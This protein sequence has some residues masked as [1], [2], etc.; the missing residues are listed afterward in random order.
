MARGQTGD[1]ALQRPNAPAGADQPG[2]ATAI[3]W[4]QKLQHLLRALAFCLAIAAIQCAFMPAM[5]YRVAAGYSLAIGMPTWALI[6]LGRHLFPG[7][8]GRPWPAGIG[9]VLLPASAL[10]LSYLG[11]VQ[12]ADW[13]FDQ[14]TWSGGWH[15]RSIG[16]TLLSGTICT[17]YFYN[18]GKSAW[19]QARMTEVR[20]QATQAQ[21]NLLQAQLEPHM[22]FNTLANLRTLIASDPA[23]AQ[24]M[25]D[26]MIAYLRATL[27]AS[28][29]SSGHRLDHE[30]ERLRD[31]L[32]LM[33]MR[34]GARLRYTL[35]LPDAL[36]ALP[37]PPLLLQPLVEN[38]IRHGLEPQVAGGCI[39]VRASSGGAA[40]GALLLEVCDTGAGLPAAADRLPA[41]ASGQ[42]FGLAQVRE[43]LAALHGD[44]ASLTLGANGARGTRACISLPLPAASCPPPVAG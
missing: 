32:E 25:L 19:L 3:D 8:D 38:A 17:Y 35:E 10:G 1:P 44:A 9:A 16:I 41:G 34:M 26:H 37:V 36:R 22:L 7:P 28:R 6:D 27:G 30:F 33:V 42:S 43:R 18:R 40:G 23:R 15:W 39:S 31:Y 2:A 4:M 20:G 29:S 12:L 11:G 24:H 13:Y 5:P 21:L 14:R